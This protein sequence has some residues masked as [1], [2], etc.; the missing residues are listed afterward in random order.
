MN[1]TI[2]E[3]DEYRENE[4]FVR[5]LSSS[6]YNTDQT[7][8]PIRKSL[9]TQQTNDEYEKTVDLFLSNILDSVKIELST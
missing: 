2:Y 8:I 5:A 3:N 9:E 7:L 1:N 4:L 6:I